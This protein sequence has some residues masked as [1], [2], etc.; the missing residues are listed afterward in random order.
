MLFVRIYFTY[1]YMPVL[2]VCQ[3]VHLT[4]RYKSL[5]GSYAHYTIHFLP[6]ISHLISI[7]FFLFFSSYSRAF[8]HPCIHPSIHPCISLAVTVGSIHE[9]TR[10]WKSRW[11]RNGFSF[12]TAIPRWSTGHGSCHG[13]IALPSLLFPAR[14]TYKNLN[15]TCD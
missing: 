5:K 6:P 4:A 3:S 10:S 9:R 11:R 8:L 12:F 15:K 14:F 1:I 2:F 13:M 7:L